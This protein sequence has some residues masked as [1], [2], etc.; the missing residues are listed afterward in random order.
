MNLSNLCPPAVLVSC[1]C[2]TAGLLQLAYR[3]EADSSL[4]T[5]MEDLGQRLNAACSVG[6]AIDSSS[7]TM[8]CSFLA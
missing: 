2:F 8:K 3:D 5:R 4:A 1:H 7:T 6:N